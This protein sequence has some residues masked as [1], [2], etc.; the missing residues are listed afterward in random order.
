MRTG[1]VREIRRFGGKMENRYVR[2]KS[3]GSLIRVL[4]ICMVILLA[5]IAVRIGIAA[6]D[7]AYGMDFKLVERIDTRISNPH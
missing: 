4:M 5:F 7:L 3:K 1:L 6:G 2:K